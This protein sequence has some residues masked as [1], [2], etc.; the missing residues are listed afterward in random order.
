MRKNEKINI[1]LCVDFNYLDPLVTLMKSV[2]YHHS[3]VKFY[4]FHKTLASE[5]FE[6][7]DS[8]L[9][10]LSKGRVEVENVF[11]KTDNFKEFKTLDYISEVTYYRYLIQFL[12]EDRVLYIDSDVIVDGSLEDI[13][14][15]DFKEN[16]ICA[17]PDFVL[18]HDKCEHSYKEFPN[19]KPYFNA[20]FMLINNKLWKEKN[21]VQT[22]YYLTENCKNAIYADQDILNIALK[23]GWK[24]LDKK[25]N[26]QVHAGDSLKNLGVDYNMRKELN[27]GFKPVVI[28][29]TSIKKPWKNNYYDIIF[30]E[31]YW[32]YNQLSW[33]E[34]FKN[35]R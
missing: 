24:A 18:N 32:F 28:H 21:L 8:K 11:V 3:N 23:N 22:L 30:R 25:Y 20:G 17:V 9:K 10:K 26:Y 33:E 13:Y 14:F 19:M 34:I 27:E 31:K 7:I 29:Y 1:V 2:C 15:S 16:Y 4:I 35:K 6:N 12:E 5:W